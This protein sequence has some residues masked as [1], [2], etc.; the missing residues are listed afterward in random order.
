[1]FLTVISVTLLFP[2]STMLAEGGKNRLT[3]TFG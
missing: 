1:M 2:W 3:A